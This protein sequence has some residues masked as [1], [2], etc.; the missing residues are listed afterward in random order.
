MDFDFDDIQ[1]AIN[2]FPVKEPI[3]DVLKQNLNNEDIKQIGNFAS[4]FQDLPKGFINHS[5]EDEE[6][7]SSKDS[8][9]E[10][11]EDE[12]DEEEEEEEEKEEEEDKHFDKK[13]SIKNGI[14]ELVGNVM[15][16]K[17][18]RDF[19][20]T[21]E[22]EE[23]TKNTVDYVLE[24]GKEIAAHMDQFPEGKKQ[25]KNCVHFVAKNQGEI[26]KT[27]DNL[28]DNKQQIKDTINEKIGDESIKEVI[29]YALDNEELI[30]NAL[31]V[32]LGAVK[33]ADDNCIIC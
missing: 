17:E 26:E 25:I 2:Y 20:F 18:L 4:Q 22:D 9:D 3:K 5:S 1:D 32:G 30:K 8:S 11:E 23:I 21:K 31:K 24:N 14:N 10:D 19:N 28:I 27:I 6:K 12:E 13:E 7:R 15:S 16:Q 33:Y 29:N